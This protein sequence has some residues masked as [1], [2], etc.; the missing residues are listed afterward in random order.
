VAGEGARLLALLAADAD[1]RRV[2]LDPGAGR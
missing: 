2:Q 1:D